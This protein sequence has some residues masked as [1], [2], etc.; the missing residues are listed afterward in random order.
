MVNLNQ[1]WPAVGPFSLWAESTSSMIV[2]HLGEMSAARWRHTPCQDHVTNLRSL[3][4]ILLR[5]ARLAVDNF[6]F[7]ESLQVTPDLPEVQKYYR[8]MLYHTIR[9]APSHRGGSRNF[10]NGGKE[11]G[12]PFEKIVVAKNIEI[13]GCMAGVGV[14]RV[15]KRGRGSRLLRLK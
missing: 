4:T 7:S 13:L 14:H 15:L 9:N 3:N 10:Q 2:V 8:E 1:T 6:C 12:S 11:W 5:S